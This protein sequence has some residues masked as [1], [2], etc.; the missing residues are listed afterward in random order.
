[1][2]DEMMTLLETEQVGEDDKKV[3]YVKSF[4]NRDDKG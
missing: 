2:I 1:M 3:N 4:D